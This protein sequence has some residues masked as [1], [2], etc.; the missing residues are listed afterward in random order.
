MKLTF[1][2]HGGDFRVP[3]G[4][5]ARYEAVLARALKGDGPIKVTVEPN[6]QQ[7]TLRENAYFHV[8]CKRLSEMAGGT[9]EDIREMAKAKAVSLGYP[10]ATAEE[11][12][13]IAGKHGM[14]GIPSSEAN[15]GECNLLIE[16][17]YMMASENGYYLED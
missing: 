7:R 11:R 5:E 14:M 6:F 16:A 2:I 9:P 10:I 8:L 12:I 3:A 13:P 17:V 15:I 1:V 4:F